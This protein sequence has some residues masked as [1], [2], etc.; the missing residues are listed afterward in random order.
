MLVTV[1]AARNVPPAATAAS[2]SRSAYANRVYDSPNPNGRTG[3]GSVDVTSD[4]PP[5]TGWR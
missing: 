3:V 2:T 4:G 5:S 1:T